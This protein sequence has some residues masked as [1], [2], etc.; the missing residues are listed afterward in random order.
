MEF[1][2]VGTSL[3]I[4]FLQVLI[5]C[6]LSMRCRVSCPGREILQVLGQSWG[7]WRSVRRQTHSCPG[8]YDRH[9]TPPIHVKHL[10]YGPLWSLC[11]NPKDNCL[12]LW[13]LTS[14]H[15]FLELLSFI[16]LHG[17]TLSGCS[18]Y[19]LGLYFL[20]SF[21]NVPPVYSL[22]VCT[23]HGPPH[24]RVLMRTFLG[25]LNP[26]TVYWLPFTSKW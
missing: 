15:S 13:H 24:G 17:V 9:L 14:Q 22:T 3:C 8:V 26:F 1:L 5:G 11:A 18:F 20:S 10:L 2:V 4:Y 21:W 6:L 16:G 12:P 25:W 23:Y 19:M 7:S